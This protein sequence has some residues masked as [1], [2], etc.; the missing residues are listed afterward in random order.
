[1]MHRDMK[2]ATEAVLKA[3]QPR[4][5]NRAYEALREL[6]EVLHLILPRIDRRTTRIVAL[7][8]EVKSLRE[9]LDK[10]TNKEKNKWMITDR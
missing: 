7:E 8:A 10:E 2:K 5:N 1:M 9:D 4:S 6:E 3:W